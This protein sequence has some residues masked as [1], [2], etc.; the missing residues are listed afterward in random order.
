MSK[1]MKRN[2]DAIEEALVMRAFKEAE[3]RTEKRKQ[4]VALLCYRELIPADL[5]KRLDELPDGWVPKTSMVTLSLPGVYEH[6]NLDA[7][8][9]CPHSMY[10]IGSIEYDKKGTIADAVL[11]LKKESD[12][13][14]KKKRDVRNEVRGVLR[15]ITTWGRLFEVWPEAKDVIELLVPVTSGHALARIPQELNTALNLP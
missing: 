2:R 1:L 14:D 8:R 13:L 4:A 12:A 10:C 9:S 15:G 11:T 5:E 3:A 6:W 7:P